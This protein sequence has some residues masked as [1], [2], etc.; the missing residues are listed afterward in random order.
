[1]FKS[2]A[3]GFPRLGKN[4]EFK[5]ATENF[6][7]GKI[8]ELEFLQEMSRLK[9]SIAENY[10]KYVDMFPEGE[11]TLYDNMLDTAIML[12]VYKVNNLADYFNLCRGKEALELT[13]WFN[14]NYHYLVP[15]IRKGFEPSLNLEWLN[16]YK[17]THKSDIL[18]LIGPFTFLKLSKGEAKDNFFEILEKLA[19]LYTEIAA[20]Y[21]HLHIDEPAL[22]L[23]LS[24]EEIQSLMR[25]YRK[26]AAKGKVRLFTYYDSVELLEELYNLPLE[27]IGLDFVSNA[28]NLRIIEERGFPQ[29]KTLIAGVVT[30][31][32]VWRTN[33]QKIS[34]ILERLAQ[35]TKNIV[36]SNAA[37][38]YHLPFS[39][40]NETSLPPEL[41]SALAFAKERLGEIRN[42]AGK[43]AQE[44]IIFSP[45]ENSSLRLKIKELKED[46]FIKS[47]SLEERQKIQKEELDLPLFPTTTIGSFPQ[48][49]E[50]RKKRHLFRKGEIGIAE[51][52]SFIRE[53][54]K[55][56]VRYQEEKG[57][58]VLVH[59][60]F[61]RTDMVEF[62]AQKLEGIA[63]TD[64]GWIISY[65]TR[66]YRPPIIYSD[67]SRPSDMTIEEISYAQSLTKKPVKGMLTG[68][69]TIIAWSFVREDIPIKEVAFQLSLALQEEIAAYERNDIKIVQIDE[70]A[71]REKAPLK[72]KKWREYFDWA[73][74]SFNLAS[75]QVR[76]QTQIHTHMCYSEFGEIIEEINKLDFDVITIETARSRGD[77]IKDFERIE[78]KKQIGLGVWDI[79]SPAVPS[80]EEM[81]KVVERALEKLPKENFWINPDC[82]LKT[83][84]WPEVSDSLDNMVSLAKDLRNRYQTIKK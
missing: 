45:K 20:S 3:Y 70:P 73:V 51:Y 60:E 1:M 10:R 35:H 78:F 72:K 49:S 31:R 76:P 24:Q 54:I 33:Y 15:F 42:I 82:G 13:K 36:V 77:I 62:F 44:E 17:L 28:E 59:G 84:N 61:E 16:R 48:D 14:T 67:I 83:R 38:L 56:L 18:Y 30:G 75:S 53:K 34:K 12:G 4:R 11:F 25:A 41:K 69:V 58:D 43:E 9:D 79:H 74:K 6:W 40:E 8:K 64:S 68:P 21:K 22:V 71:F 5:K 2:Y 29:E 50:V 26:I 32:N 81:Q 37:P 65:G 52:K 47:H 39:I 66:C 27:G 57:L 55:S 7:K 23:D 46:A 19:D 63:T 80:K